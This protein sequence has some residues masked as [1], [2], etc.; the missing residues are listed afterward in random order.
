[1]LEERGIKEDDKNYEIELE[2]SK[3]KATRNLFLIRHGQY[4]LKGNGDEERTLTALG[5]EQAEY[6]GIWFV[7]WIYFFFITSS[8]L[9]Q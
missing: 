8:M 4:N 3:P 6:T 5:R 1:M 7:F 2:K 9:K